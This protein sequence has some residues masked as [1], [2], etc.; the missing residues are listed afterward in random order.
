MT[1]RQL[2]MKMSAA[3]FRPRGGALIG[4][5]GALLLLAAGRTA[6]AQTPPGD[7]FSTNTGTYSDQF[8]TDCSSRNTSP[9]AGMDPLSCYGVMMPTDSR[10]VCSGARGWR[11]LKQVGS[12]C[13]FCQPINPPINGIIV[14]LDQLNLA[15]QQGYVCGVDQSNPNCM[16]VCRREGPITTY[17]PPRPAP[18]SFSSGNGCVPPDYLSPAQR[19]R[20]YRENIL[21]G[22]V[23]CPGAYNPCDNP[24]APAWCRAAQK[25]VNAP[26]DVRA[27]VP[28]AAP[29]ERYILGFERGFATCLEN[30][31]T[32]QNIALYA[33][34]ARF[35]AIGAILQI[36]AAPAAIQGVLNPPGVSPNPNPYLRG[37][38]EGFRLCDWA[39]KV[40]PIMVRRCPS[41]VP[42]RIGP[43]EP[44]GSC[45]AEEPGFGSSTPFPAK[46]VDCVPCTL[47]YLEGRP[48]TPPP[49]GTTPTPVST[50]MVELRTR[51][52]N[53]VPQGPPLPCWRMKLQANGLAGESTPTQ[54][55]A[56]MK[57]AGP[58][59]KGIV[60]YNVAGDP[61]GHVFAVENVPVYDPATGKFI[62]EVKF[63]DEQQNMDGRLWF[64]NPNIAWWG[65][66]RIK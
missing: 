14:P 20:W 15:R 31:A 28:D 8:S 12:T 13:Y 11:L 21:S 45:I 25:C 23:R 66:Y 65:I 64:S 3:C 30:Q 10:G 24:D 38:D 33:L 52:G 47:A 42:T 46:R 1:A 32:V 26:Y 40:S 59:A 60:F 63:W 19:Q 22:K 51:F 43:S 58:G 2:S 55:E 9:Y 41:Q 49:A 27:D 50:L 5:L 7:V 4:F 56:E 53:L 48:Y 17:V 18:P 54:I 37:K 57:A 6:Y 44:S 61:V 62:D 39:L 29:Q 34:A 35:R 36:M 16:A